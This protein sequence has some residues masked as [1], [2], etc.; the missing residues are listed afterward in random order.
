VEF[1]AYGSDAFLIGR[2]FG[3]SPLGTYNRAAAILAIPTQYL[4]SGLQKVFFPVI[5]SMAEAE[6]GRQQGISLTAIFV[7][8][9]VTLPCSLGASAGASTLVAAVLGGKWHAVVPLITPLALTL[10]PN[11]TGVIYGAV[12]DAAAAFRLRAGVQLAFV[13]VLALL[14][15]VMTRLGIVGVAW[16]VMAASW[17]RWGLM[18]WAYCTISGVPLKATLSQYRFA[19]VS[20]GSVYAAILAVNAVLQG[21]L[22]VGL[23]LGCD[24]IIG[25]TTCVALAWLFPPAGARDALVALTGEGSI[26]GAT[27]KWL[28][29]LASA[30]SEEFVGKLRLGQFAK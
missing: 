22:A 21:R 4:M 30:S 25:A 9:S 7:A 20:S 14:Y 11:F 24:L 27:P 8:A 26:Q 15:S 19:I 2:M 13:A 5:S 17:C 28:T 1:I 16:A 6:T 18:Q 3:A 10:T 12:L 29:Y 23:M